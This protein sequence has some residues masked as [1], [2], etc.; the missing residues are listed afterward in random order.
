M[1][2]VLPSTKQEARE[3]GSKFYFTGKAC[4]ND[5]VSERRTTTGQCIECARL[6]NRKWYEA[7]R[8]DE[9]ARSRADYEADREGRISRAAQWA[10]D[11]PDRVRENQ[12]QAR[13]RD[14]EKSREKSREFRRRKPE[15]A[16]AAVSRWLKA[17]PD[18][19]NEHRAHRRASKLQATPSWL[20]AE[21]RAKIGKMYAEAKRLTEETGIAYHVDHIEPLRGKTSC[22][23]HV[24]WNLQVLTWEDNLKKGNRIS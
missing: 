18:R 3:V 8:E 13:A 6:V 15:V 7:H 4:S 1:T 20:S 5:H 21:H 19:Q 11:N 16:R 17:N 10:K 2:S 14:P 23:L 12:A 9:N 24:P 22:G